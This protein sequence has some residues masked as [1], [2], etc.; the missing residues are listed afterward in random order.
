MGDIPFTIDDINN[1][2]ERKTTLVQRI[3]DISGN[4]ISEQTMSLLKKML[5]PNP[6]TR[7]T[8]Y[9]LRDQIQR[10]VANPAICPSSSMNFVKEQKPARNTST[11]Q[12]RRY[13]NVAE[14]RGASVHSARIGPSQFKFNPSQSPNKVISSTQRIQSS[15]ITQNI[16]H[17]SDSVMQP[18]RIT[19]DNSTS[20]SRAATQDNSQSGI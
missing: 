8:C 2:L 20:L 5:D 3:K 18:R 9:Q 10:I 6:R 11:N 12:S 14:D 4:R 7:I 15:Q 17:G 16:A 19:G 13:F 1:L